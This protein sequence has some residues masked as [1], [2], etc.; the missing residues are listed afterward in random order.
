MQAAAAAAAAAAANG[1]DRDA[2]REAVR[3]CEAACAEDGALDKLL[4]CA[5][6]SVHAAC[7]ASARLGLCRYCWLPAGHRGA[8]TCIC[9]DVLARFSEIASAS[10]NAGAGRA[11]SPLR[12]RWVVVCH[13]NEFLRSVS[14]AK[15]ARPD[16]SQTR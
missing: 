12:V 11:I 10:A 2:M 13:P 15:L 9:G 7:A 16:T 1:G 5:T 4:F 14:T 8:G 3:A 6:A